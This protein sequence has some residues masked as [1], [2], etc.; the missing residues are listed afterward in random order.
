MRDRRPS[1]DTRLTLLMGAGFGGVAL[2]LLAIT[3]EPDP[4][5]LAALGLFIT[6]LAAM[7]FLGYRLS[8]EA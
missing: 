8:Q 6:L 2:Q 5:R 4:T 7:L 3:D 1:E